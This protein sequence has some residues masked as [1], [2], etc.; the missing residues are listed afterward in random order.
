MLDEESWQELFGG[1]LSAVAEEDRPALVPHS[2]CR[3]ATHHA[4]I[5]DRAWPATLSWSAKPACMTD[6]YL[7]FMCAHCGLSGNALLVRVGLVESDRLCGR[8]VRMTD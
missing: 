5:R 1:D 2:P 4:A 8:T 6:I 7:H 3:T